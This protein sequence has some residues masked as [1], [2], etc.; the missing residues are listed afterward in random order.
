MIVKNPIPY[1][2]QE[3]S[4]LVEEYIT[5]QRAEFTLKELYTYIVYWG[6]EEK[7]IVGDCL[8]P[9]EKAKVNVILKRI[10]KDGRISVATID[11]TKYLK[12]NASLGGNNNQSKN[13]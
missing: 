2:I 12:N 9:C 13:I 3:L 1:T 5:Q 10:V 8:M 11:F 4:V 6:L 7:R